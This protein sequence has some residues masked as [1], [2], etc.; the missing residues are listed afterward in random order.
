[1]SQ[2][3]SLSQLGPAAR[4]QAAKLIADETRRRKHDAALKVN[5]NPLPANHNPDTRRAVSFTMPIPPSVNHLFKNAGKQ[6][7]KTAEYV[8]WIQ[9]AATAL[10]AQAVPYTCGNIAI[11][12]LIHRVAL[13]SDIDNRIKSALD[14]L[15]RN[16][17]IDNDRHVVEIHAAWAEVE[18]CTVRVEPR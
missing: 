13:N 9:R 4:A 5:P 14:A 7:I 12:L 17:V 10:Q 8:D 3:V 6:R 15:V 16:H 18:T 11:Y 1:M 2:N